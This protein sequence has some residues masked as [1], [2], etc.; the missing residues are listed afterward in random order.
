MNYDTLYRILDTIDLL[1]SPDYFSSLTTV[2]NSVESLPAGHN[3]NGA[4]AVS[5][6]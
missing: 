1:L 2:P 5:T 6:N 4:R 3:Y